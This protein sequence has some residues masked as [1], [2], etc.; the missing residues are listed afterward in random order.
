MNNYLLK[1]LGILFVLSA[2]GTNKTYAPTR[3]GSKANP[4]AEDQVQQTAQPE[5]T[6]E[7]SAVASVIPEP[8]VTEAPETPEVQIVIPKL[9]LKFPEVSAYGLSDAELKEIDLITSDS[10]SGLLLSS[11]SGKS[12]SLDVATKKATPIV[13]HKAP[14]MNSRLSSKSVSWQISADKLTKV[15]VA[16]ASAVAKSVAMEFSKL[17]SEPNA[18]PK[19]VG[20]NSSKLFMI[21][22]N[23]LVNFSGDSKSLSAQKLSF[24]TNIVASQF[25]SA[26]PLGEKNYWVA[27]TKRAYL[28]SISDDGKQSQWR[29]YEF[30]LDKE[31][32]GLKQISIVQID[33]NNVQ[34]IALSDKGIAVSEATSTKVDLPEVQN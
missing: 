3:E 34:V 14:A 17:T 1:S 16:D 19:A 12:W 7:P 5:P 15:E 23:K 13:A 11:A 9:T 29:E 18:S 21:V 10:K 20:L 31:I 28:V 33:E 32:E 27:T 6:A 4:S 2:C 30:Q 22:G 25:T 24:P 8:N 26:G